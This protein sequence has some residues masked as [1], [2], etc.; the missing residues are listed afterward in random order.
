MAAYTHAQPANAVQVEGGANNNGLSE[1]PARVASASAAQVSV[2]PPPAMQESHPAGEAVTVAHATQVAASAE[3]ETL[4][5]GTGTAYAPEA[6]SISTSHMHA[7]AESLASQPGNSIGST[8]DAVTARV[9]A[10]L[11]AAA[12][13]VA[14]AAHAS[15]ADHH[16]IAQVVH[17]VMERM[18]G[19]LVEE[20]VRE[21]KSKR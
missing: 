14:E 19:D 2:A 15:G 3:P 7:E 13:A 6:T 17:R 10:E 9:E 8:A 11:P 20:I 12:S 18:K 16:S 1:V 5:E 4:V 21:L